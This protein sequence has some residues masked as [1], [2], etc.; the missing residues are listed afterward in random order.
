MTAGGAYLALY[1]GDMTRQNPQAIGSLSGA[2]LALQFASIALSVVYFFLPPLVHYT[3]VA[4]CVA[5]AAG[6]IQRA[7]P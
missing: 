5:L 6:G 2:F 1:L 4:I 7:K 3:L